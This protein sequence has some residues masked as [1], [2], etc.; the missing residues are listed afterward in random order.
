MHAHVVE[1]HHFFRNLLHTMEDSFFDNFL[2]LIYS[3]S[4]DCFTGGFSERFPRPPDDDAR[5]SEPDAVDRELWEIIKKNPSGQTDVQPGPQNREKVPRMSK[6]FQTP[7][8]V[9]VSL[10]EKPI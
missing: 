4:F 1:L 9:S 6:S 3:E 2:P 7:L 5:T 10:V 8:S